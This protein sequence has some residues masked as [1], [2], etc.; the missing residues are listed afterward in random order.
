LDSTL[1]MTNKEDISAAYQEFQR[2]HLEQVPYIWLLFYY[3]N[4]V[5][6]SDRLSN[7]TVPNVTDAPWAF[8]EWKVAY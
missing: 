5:Y 1:D 8:W 6:N 2:V 3:E 7:V 4:F